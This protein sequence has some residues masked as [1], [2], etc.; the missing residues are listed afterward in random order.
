MRVLLNKVLLVIA[1]IYLLIFSLIQITT[2]VYLIRLVLRLQEL[3]GK[4]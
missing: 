4:K 3:F 1:V 2:D